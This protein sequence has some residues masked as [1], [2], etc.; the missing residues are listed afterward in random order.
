MRC[1]RVLTGL[2]WLVLP[3][4]VGQAAETVRAALVVGNN[5]GTAARHPLRYAE[6]DAKSL[7][8]VLSELG[9]F[10]PQNVH[11]LT[12]RP[13]ATVAKVLEELRRKIQHWH[14]TDRRV[15][16]LFYF[17]GHSDGEALELGSERWAYREVRERLKD[18]GAD[19][20][21]VIV[22]SCQ[23]GALL[24][25]KGGLPGPNFDIRFS[26]D[27]ATT[28]EAVL[29]SSAADEMALESGEIRASFFSHHLIS[30]LRGAADSSGDGRV[31]LS[32][33]YRHAFD[34]TLL[35]TSGTLRGP[36][37]PGYDYRMSGQ[38][39]LVLTEVLTRGATLVLPQH[40]DQILIVDE[41]QR[42]LLAELT[43]QS[44]NRI[45]LPPGRYI[46]RARLGRRA[47]EGRVKLA[48]L[49]TRIVR[50]EELLPAMEAGAAAK[51]SVAE[52]DESAPVATWMLSAEAG[53]QR[54]VA[55]ALPWLAQV[56]VAA[57]SADR[58]GWTAGLELATGRTDGFRESAV[59]A[60]VG[61]FR[62]R[63]WQLLSAE[64]GWRLVGGRMVQALDAGESFASWVGGGGP[65]LA[66]GLR[67]TPRTMLSV[68]IGIDG[69]L[70]RRDVSTHIQLSP[71]AHT[72]VRVA[73]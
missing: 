45:A 59:R 39:E 40:F 73:F 5:L 58:V 37:H 51:G 53:A 24:A 15:V 26:D 4:A 61:I 30:G 35:A 29:T 56:R 31:T 67:L 63:S 43:R 14:S 11:I 34:S 8:Q 12:G 23:S 22:D 20:R 57:R 66:A 68:A 49:E 33:A 52:V 69:L 72:G 17:S 3:P 62:A 25:D 41:S 9:G 60:T 48:Q 50:T 64:L 47:Y 21:I 1:A 55:A 28:G 32:E 6:E 16:L 46:L 42:R 38:G 65:W 19:I 71:N 2:V 70:L 44:A 13:L 7:G 36:Q 54:G 18:V 27:R 10:E